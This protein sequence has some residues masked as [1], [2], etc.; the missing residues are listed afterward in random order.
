MLIDYGGFVKIKKNIRSNNIFS[1]SHNYRVSMSSNSVGK[2][3]YKWY[4]RDLRS[5]LI[6]IKILTTCSP[7]LI[8]NS[9]QFSPVQFISVQF[10]YIQFSS[11]QL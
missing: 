8:F 10:S 1:I 11:F 5:N 3:L 6:Y 7:Q 2:I 9:A 4:M